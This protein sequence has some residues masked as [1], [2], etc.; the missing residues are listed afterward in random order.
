M[1]REYLTRKNDLILQATILMKQ[2]KIHEYRVGKKKND[3]SSEQSPDR[4]KAAQKNQQ[5][6]RLKK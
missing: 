1:Q 4:Q 5:Q 3:D 2:E 6:K